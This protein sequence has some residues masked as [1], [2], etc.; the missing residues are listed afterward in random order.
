MT[1]EYVRAVAEAGEYVRAHRRLLGD[2]VTHVLPFERA[3]DAYD[4]AE[5]PAPGQRKVDVRIGAGG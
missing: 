4:L 3:R 5:R 2:Y 1:R